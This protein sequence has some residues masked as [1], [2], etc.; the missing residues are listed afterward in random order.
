MMTFGSY[1]DANKCCKVLKYHEILQKH[2]RESI[3]HKIVKIKEMKI[4]FSSYPLRIVH[5]HKCDDVLK[6]FRY[7]R[8]KNQN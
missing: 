5:G 8:M 7:K 3:F 1:F 6:L 4:S 2:S